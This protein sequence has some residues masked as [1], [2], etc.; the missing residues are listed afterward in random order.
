[1]NI[2][3][4]IAKQV[5][6]VYE[7]N[8]WTDVS[9]MET[10]QDI[11][12]EEATTITSASVNSIAMLLHHCNYYNEMV[13]QRLMG[14]TPQANESNGFDLPEILSENDWNA[15]KEQSRLSA[16]QLADAIREFPENKLTEINPASGDSFYKTIAGVTEHTH[17]HLGQMV[18][19]KNYIRFIKN[20]SL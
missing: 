7:G 14:N 15:L 20:D 10:L 2:I 11:N 4:C 3:D 5:I 8:N 1:M 12:F 16:Q 17:Y 9:I 18:I 19:L 13:C 6:E